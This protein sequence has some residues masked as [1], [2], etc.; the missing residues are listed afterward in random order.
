M[1]P[2]AAEIRTLVAFVAANMALMPESVDTGLLL[3]DGQYQRRGHSSLEGRCSRWKSSRRSR[4]S[5]GNPSDREVKRGER[6][7][8]FLELERT[9]REFGA[10]RRGEAAA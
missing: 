2:R 4:R 3:T 6:G 10:A 7:R 1:Q 9:M 8:R 5:I